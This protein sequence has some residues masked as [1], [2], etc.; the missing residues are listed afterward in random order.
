VTLP[1]QPHPDFASFR[2]SWQ[3]AMEADGYP[4][5]TRRS[6]TR[7]LA[8]FSGWLALHHPDTAPAA[9]TREHVRGWI[10]H[11]RDTTSSG[12][13]RSHFAGLRHFCRWMVAEGEAAADATDGIKTP[14]PNDPTTPL[15]KVEELRA[16]LAECTGNDFVARRD[17]AIVYAFADGGLRLAECAGLAVVDVDV[18][19]RTLAVLGKGSNRSGP[20]RRT[21]PLGVKAARALDRYLRERRKHPYAELG[22][23]WL[24]DRGRAALSADG[25][26]AMLQRRAAR[27]G[28][29]HIHPHQFRH[30]WADAFR[31]AGGSEGDLMTLGGWRG[32][33]MLDRY[34]KSN[35]EGRAREAYARLSLGDR[36]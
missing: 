6:Y 13:A 18:R 36:L 5:N 35:A 12:T 21:V 22:A 15:L 19:E 30:T 14:A 24:G 20:R 1:P 4:D 11:T 10:V 8:S 28:I 17:T 16:L 32:R 29:G 23:L 3:L 9:A 7:A 26:D 34:G 33:A 27:A 31:A 2:D 25:I